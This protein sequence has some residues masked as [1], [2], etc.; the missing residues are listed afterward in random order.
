LPVSSIFLHQNSFLKSTKFTR[1]STF[2]HH[3]SFWIAADL[4][5]CLYPYWTVLYSIE[6]TC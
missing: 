6:T 4:W 5:I 2:P 3:W 1:F